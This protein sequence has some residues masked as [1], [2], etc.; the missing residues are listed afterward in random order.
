LRLSR[1]TT[2]SGDQPGRRGAGQEVHD[3]GQGG[4]G[5]DDLGF[6]HLPVF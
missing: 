6:G 2:A 1:S 5:S 4:E 3:A